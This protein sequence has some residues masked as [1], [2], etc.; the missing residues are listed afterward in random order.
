LPNNLRNDFWESTPNLGKIWDDIVPGVPR[1]TIP[2]NADQGGDRTATAKSP[3]GE[4]HPD[5]IS[6]V[7]PTPETTRY[8]GSDRARRSIHI[9]LMFSCYARDDDRLRS[10]G[11]LS[12]QGSPGA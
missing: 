8:G 10:A 11:H 5:A 3:V 2:L 9:L 7:G 12:T 6:D 1:Q 4:D